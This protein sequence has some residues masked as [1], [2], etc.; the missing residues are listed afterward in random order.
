MNQKDLL[1]ILTRKIC[2]QLILSRVAVKPQSN[3]YLN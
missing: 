2:Q 3:N 1:R